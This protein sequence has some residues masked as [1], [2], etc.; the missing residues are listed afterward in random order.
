MPTQTEA[1]A[2]PW[3]LC[4]GYSP[5]FM[6]ID[7]CDGYIVFQ[8]ADA[9]YK[10]ESGKPIPCPSP[11]AQRANAKLIVQAVNEH[12]ALNAVAEAAERAMHDINNPGDVLPRNQSTLSLATQQM[13]KEALSALQSLRTKGSR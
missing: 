10:F 6:G 5:Q 2:R 9:A 12:S 7:S 4:G 3:K 11:E 13:L 8:F 1:T